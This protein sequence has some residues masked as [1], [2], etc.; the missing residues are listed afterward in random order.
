ME[1]KG[2]DDEEKHQEKDSYEFKSEAKSADKPKLDADYLIN[3]LE[4]YFYEDTDLAHT[5][6]NYIK[7]KAGIVNLESE[8]YSLSYTEAH[9][10]Y[11][12]MFETRMERQI[13]K[14]GATPVDFYQALQEK[15]E[16]D[17]D[18]HVAMFAQILLAVTEF[19]IFMT[20]MRE[21]ARSFH[22]GRK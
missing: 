5:F 8:E 4:R 7:D 11:R 12:D 21:A 15:T 14:L 6:E 3:E 16:N 18:G 9:N 10:E 2:E 13:E 1:S 17:K 20:M 19:D 22:S